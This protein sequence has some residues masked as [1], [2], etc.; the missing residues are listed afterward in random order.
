MPRA[1]AVPPG[2]LIAQRPSW[3]ARY[4][5]DRLRANTVPVAAAIYDDDMYLDHDLS[6]TT[7]QTI[8]GL[9]PWITNEYQHNG[10]RAS[11]GAVLDHLIALIRETP[12]NSFSTSDRMT[13]RGIFA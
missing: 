5:A 3:P 12:W 10:L 4:D 2:H 7:A 8:R 1:T 11:N 13:R 6:I 9:R